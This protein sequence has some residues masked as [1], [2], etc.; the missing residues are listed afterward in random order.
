MGNSNVSKLACVVAVAITTGFTVGE[1]W[2]ASVR[3]TTP[4][5]AGTIADYKAVTW[6]LQGAGQKFN[7]SVIPLLKDFDLVA[8]QEAGP[9][10]STEANKLDQIQVQTFSYEQPDKSRVD[11]KVKVYEW[12]YAGT[13]RGN[14][15]YIYHMTTDDGGN[16][17]NLATVLKQKAKS[18]KF[19]APQPDNTYRNELGRPFFAVEM[20]NGSLFFNMH[21]GSYGNNQ[22]NDAD[23]IVAAVAKDFVGKNWAI[24]GDFNREPHL[25]VIP[26]SAEKKVSGKATTGFSAATNRSTGK[27]KSDPRE[28]DWM[29]ASKGSD[30][31]YKAELFKGGD[32]DHAAVAF[33]KK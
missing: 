14:P 6:N 18:I 27:T 12:K 31:R 25:V 1:A 29:V 20:A 9:E 19:M 24:L 33:W 10:P 23:N 3:P 2:A 13:S 7:D 16:R 17:V 11:V 22:Y 30:P 28:L 32:A 5:A 15:A 26:A 8:I 4:T 21:A